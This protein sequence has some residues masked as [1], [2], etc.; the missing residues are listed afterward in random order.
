MGR[1]AEVALQLAKKILEMEAELSA[2]RSRFEKFVEGESV[3]R[4]EESA[5][6]EGDESEETRTA[7]EDARQA[8]IG[9]RGT[10]SP[11]NS[12]ERVLRI[13][14]DL[15]PR[16]ATPSDIGQRMSD[17][18]PKVLRNTLLRLSKEPESPLERLGRGMYR[19]RGAPAERT[20]G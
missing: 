8:V 18:D 4:E 12:P 14:R 13:M 1:Q 20:T 9:L 5:G 17:V 6:D 10:R 2:L 11:R 7:M 3:D 19:L 15:Y 16:G